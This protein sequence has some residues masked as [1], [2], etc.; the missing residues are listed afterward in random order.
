[1]YA[2]H[3][4]IVLIDIDTTGINK[5]HQTRCCCGVVQLMNGGVSGVHVIRAVAGVTYNYSGGWL[6]RFFKILVLQYLFPY[7]HTLLV[8]CAP[9]SLCL[10]CHGLQMKINLAK[11]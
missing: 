4:A 1:M 6:R 10:H 9:Y 7:F 3:I 8:M 2:A 5:D 11:G